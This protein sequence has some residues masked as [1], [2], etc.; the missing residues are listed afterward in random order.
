M[1]FDIQRSSV[2]IETFRVASIRGKFD[3]S[4]DKICERFSGTLILPEEWSV[5]VIV[6]HSGTGKTTIAR[7]LFPDQYFAGFEYQAASVVDDMPN[8]ATV[9]EIVSMFMSVGFASTPSWLKPY[10]VLSQGER[11][12]VDLARA[13]L[14]SSDM[15]VFDEFTSVVDR[16][17]AR[18]ASMAVAKSVRKHKRQ[19]VAVSCHADILPYLDPDWV[20]DTNTM[21]FSRR[22][23]VVC[24]L[25]SNWRSQASVMGADFGRCLPGITI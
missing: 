12:R 11:M 9:D 15:I 18:V 1:K 20:L 16:D 13:L 23:F 8:S 5:G 17:V 4:N 22:P 7:E 14:G 25:R 21:E 6:G 10:A 2:P 24:D 3:L 19:F